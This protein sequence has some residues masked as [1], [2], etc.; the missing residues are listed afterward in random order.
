[1]KDPRF[2]GMVIYSVLAV[3]AR[4]SSLPRTD[5][6]ARHLPRGRR[7]AAPSLPRCWRCSPR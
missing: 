2:S 7:S 1:M 5:E 3:W 6:R 4:R